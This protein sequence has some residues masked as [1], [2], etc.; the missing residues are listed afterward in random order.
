[1]EYKTEQGL[2]IMSRIELAHYISEITQ[3]PICK[4]KKY[5]ELILKIYN[6]K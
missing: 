1:M 4:D 3:T 6:K 5:C 2:N